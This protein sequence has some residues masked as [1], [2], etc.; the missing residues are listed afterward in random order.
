MAAN[1]DGIY[2]S[3]KLGQLILVR[4]RAAEG[5]AYTPAVPAAN[6]LTLE[7]H[8]FNGASRRRFGVH[9]RG[10]RLSRVVGTGNEASK[11][12]AF[13]PVGTV[14]ALNAYK[15]GDEVSIGGVAW[16]VSGKRD[17]TIV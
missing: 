8:A 1:V 17:E 14:A 9:A 3:D 11:R 7:L 16:S 2:E 4:L 12:R 10:V 15:T 5:A 6:A 13:L